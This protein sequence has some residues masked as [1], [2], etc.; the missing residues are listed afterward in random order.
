MELSDLIKVIHQLTR[1]V[2]RTFVK[3][4]FYN[5]NDSQILGSQD[6]ALPN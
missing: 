3:N 4:L 6:Y 1:F 5:T 2:I